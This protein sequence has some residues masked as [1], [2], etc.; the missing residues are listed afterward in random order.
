MTSVCSLRLM[1]EARRPRP[2][3]PESILSR[4][5]LRAANRADGRRAP[6]RVKP[7]SIVLWAVRVR[8]ARELE[9]SSGQ[10]EAVIARDPFLA[11]VEDA[12][13]EQLAVVP[14]RERQVVRHARG[15]R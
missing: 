9:V 7:A 4:V 6:A 8:E 1:H 12:H 5:R 2:N 10:R 3:A 15:W 11:G 14:I 13:P